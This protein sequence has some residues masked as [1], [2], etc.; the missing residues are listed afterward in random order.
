MDNPTG[1]DCSTNGFSILLK[2]HT[3]ELVNFLARKLDA[4]MATTQDII[5]ICNLLKGASQLKYHT[6]IYFHGFIS[7]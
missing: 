2:V 7:L 4:V 3:I 1:Y 6:V 5:E